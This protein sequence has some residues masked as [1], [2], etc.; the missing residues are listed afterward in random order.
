GHLSAGTRQAWVVVQPKG[1]GGGS[2]LLLARASTPEH[3][4]FIGQ[5][6]GGRVFLFLQTDDFWPDYH[7]LRGQQ[8]RVRTRAEGCR[9]RHGGCVQGSLRQSLGSRPVCRPVLIRPS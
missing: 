2:A 4:A 7:A 3:E 1:D 5:Q 8:V 6:S 9:L